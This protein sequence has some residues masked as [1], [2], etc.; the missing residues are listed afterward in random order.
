MSVN[1][2]SGFIPDDRKH[3]VGG[4]PADP[5]ECHK[6]IYVSGDFAVEILDEDFS[7]VYQ[8]FSF[9]VRECNTFN[10]VEN[11]LFVRVSEVDRLRVFVKK[12]RSD[13]VDSFVCAL[14]GENYGEQKMER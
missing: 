14:S 13:D 6:L 4:F 2:H 8:V 7:G 9:V 10:K 3:N 5:R 1:G 12:R 11:I